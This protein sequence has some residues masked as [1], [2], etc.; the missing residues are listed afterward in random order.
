MIKSNYL[1]ELGVEPTAPTIRRSSALV[2]LALLAAAV[3]WFAV[4]ELKAYHPAPQPEQA[5][6][7]IQ[8]PAPPGS[9]PTAAPH[10]RPKSPARGLS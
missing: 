10:T 7:A 1:E 6:T 3:A 2:I 4:V 5:A 9:V 8:R